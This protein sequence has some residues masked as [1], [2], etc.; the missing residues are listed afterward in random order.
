[1]KFGEKLI[2]QREKQWEQYYLDYQELKNILLNIETELD[3]ANRS[4][5]EQSL[6]D[7]VTSLSIHRQATASKISQEP[8]LT[9]LD[10]VCILV[11]VSFLKSCNAFS[12][13]NE[14]N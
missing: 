5:S 12:L 4:Q 13:G 9:A 8:F 6:N 11:F 14:E 2:Q 3:K 7:R 10:R 1:M